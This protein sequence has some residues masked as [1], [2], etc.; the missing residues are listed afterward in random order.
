VKALSSSPSTTHTKKKDLVTCL[1]KEECELIAC[2]DR[3]ALYLQSA[4]ETCLNQ[5]A[6]LGRQDSPTEEDLL[7]S[8]KSQGRRR[9]KVTRKCWKRTG[10]KVKEEQT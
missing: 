2:L 4:K 5:K 3:Q 6:Y 9:E 7:T 8:Q 10:E 1:S